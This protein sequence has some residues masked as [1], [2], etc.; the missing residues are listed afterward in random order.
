MNPPSLPSSCFLDSPSS[1]ARGFR[2]E[3]F[4]RFGGN[5]LFPSPG[6]LPFLSGPSCLN[7]I[8]SQRKW[9]E[10]EAGN[11]EWFEEPW[12]RNLSLLCAQASE[13]K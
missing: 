1:G 11:Q 8:V 12:G 7:T 4:L 3:G 6:T 9:L 2:L 10:T 5:L 13:G